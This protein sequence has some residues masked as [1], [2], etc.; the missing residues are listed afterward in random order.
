MT[1]LVLWILSGAIP[2][3][4]LCAY[5]AFAREV[6]MPVL[7]AFAIVSLGWLAIVA[8]QV[9]ATLLRHIRRLNNLV[10]A[11]RAQDYSIRAVIGDEADDLAELYRQINTLIND[12]ETGRHA[13]Q[14][15]LAMLRKVVG[16]IRVAIVVCDAQDRIR[17]VNP[18]AAKLLCAAPG[19]MIGEAFERTALA[20]LP[21][22]AEPRTIDH[23][24]PGA[25]SRWQVNQ[26]WYR[27]QGRPSRIVFIVDVRQ[28]LADEEILMWQRLIRVIGHEVNNSLAPISSLCQTLE[29]ILARGDPR[30]VGESVHEGLQVIGQRAKGLQE[31]I[32]VY[33][34]IARLPEADK[35]LFPVAR[36]VERVRGMFP[37]D[38]V[39]LRGEVPDTRLFGD[40]VHLEQ[41]LINLIKNALEANAGSAEPVG[42]RCRIREEGCEFEIVDNG[43]G[44]ANP[45]NLFVPFYTTKAEGAGIGLVLSRNIVAQHY[46]QLTL[47]N[48]SDGRGA[49]ARMRLPLPPEA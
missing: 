47:E 43:P 41:A 38:R 46:G 4:A 2:P 39:A 17:L 42:F 32:S 33:S 24:F 29:T 45:G 3:V 48:R 22:S 7:D 16:Q 49:V 40:P 26:L 20:T 37:A 1:T 27:H 31:F 15:L 12:L 23:T 9:R 34:R 11:A 25:E 13:E 18:A 30:D 19:D 5:V 14:E 8:T 44:I 36:L 10:E 35:V 21:L 28:V 6:S